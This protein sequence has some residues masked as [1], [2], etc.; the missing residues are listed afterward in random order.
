VAAR[1]FAQA[2][3]LYGAIEMEN[4]RT[5]E[6]TQAFR[7]AAASVQEILDDRDQAGFQKLFE[8]VRAFFGALTKK[9]SEQGAFL[10]ERVVERS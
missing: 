8:E 10:I 2:P 7:A 4:P 5:Y 9:A 3:A 1:H 6:I